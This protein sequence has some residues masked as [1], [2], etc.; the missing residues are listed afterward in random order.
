MALR[1]LRG[2]PVVSCL[3]LPGG[4]VPA[5]FVYN[6]TG[7]RRQATFNATTTSFLNDGPNLAQDLQA[8]SAVATYLNGLAVDSTV[9]T[10]TSGGTQARLPDA[11][12]STVALT[13]A[14]GNVVTDYTHDPYGS[15]ATL[16]AASA[17]RI[18]YA[19][20]E[21]D[22][23]GLSFNRNRYYNPGLGRFTSEDPI[24]LG[25]GQTNRWAYVGNDPFGFRDPYGLNRVT[26]AIGDFGH[27]VSN[28][29]DNIGNAVADPLTYSS[30]ADY[31]KQRPWSHAPLLPVEL[32]DDSAAVLGGAMV[33]GLAKALAG[34]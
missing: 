23:T 26:D 5:S 20:R 17:N 16:G 18:G 34:N 21:I 32:L 25:G 15:P 24:G 14:S 3:R 11:L 4:S 10:T 30:A 8:G 6:A 7:R 27:W 29:G 22:P 31:W 28:T 9:A 12:G 19:G 33:R 13:D 2:T 1:R